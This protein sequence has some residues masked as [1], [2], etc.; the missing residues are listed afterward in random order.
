[1]SLAARLQAFEEARLLLTKKHI[2]LS[3]ICNASRAAPSNPA[4][5]L[6]GSRNTGKLGT[7]SGVYRRIGGRQ[8]SGSCLLSSITH[9][10]GIRAAEYRVHRQASEGRAHPLYQA[11][12]SLSFHKIFCVV[13]FSWRKEQSHP[14]SRQQLLRRCQCLCRD[15]SCAESSWPISQPHPTLSTSSTFLKVRSYTVANV[16]R[17][18]H[19]GETA[20]TLSQRLQPSK[21]HAHRQR[22]HPLSHHVSKHRWPERG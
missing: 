11:C 12:V 15:L 13:H 2:L 18:Q 19:S 1:M 17:K 4:F 16:R 14:L 22:Q 20:E 10:G 7:A 3:F 5:F 9:G 21:P 6:A 8:F